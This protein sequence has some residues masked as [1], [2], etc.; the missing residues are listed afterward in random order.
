M[1][2]VQPV[3][4]VPQHDQECL[5]VA[6]LQLSSGAEYF[7]LSVLRPRYCDY[8]APNSPSRLKSSIPRNALK[9]GFQLAI[10]WATKRSFLTAFVPIP[11]QRAKFQQH[12]P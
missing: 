9:I 11:L 2:A 12:V 1:T 4:E 10:V 6:D 3:A 7:M 8:A 5:V